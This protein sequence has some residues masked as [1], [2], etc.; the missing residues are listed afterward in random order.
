MTLVLGVANGLQ[1]LQFGFN[2]LASALVIGKMVGT[3]FTRQTDAEVFNILEYKYEVRLKAI[4]DWMKSFQFSRTGVIHGQGMRRLKCS[5]LMDNIDVESLQGFASIVVLCCRYVMS[6]NAI[7]GVLEGFLGSGQEAVYPGKLG[8]HGTRLSIPVK[9]L[10]ANFVRATIDSDANSQQAADVFKWMADLAS[11]VGVSTNIQLT[12]R[13][14]HEQNR[15]FIAKVMGDM[16]PIEGA[17]DGLPREP[18]QRVEH[19]LSMATASNGL[20]HLVHGLT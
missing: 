16:K 12:S 5:S 19:T 8:D 14:A 13:R 4:P 3:A 2:E 11:D 1:Q 7:V 15:L 17:E 18:F 9:A 10:L 6:T 20:R